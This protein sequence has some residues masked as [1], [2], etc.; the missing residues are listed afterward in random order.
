MELRD[1][2]EW[3]ADLGPFRG[4]DVDGGELQDELVRRG[5]LVEIPTPEGFVTDADADHVFVFTWSPHA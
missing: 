2:L 4:Q 5:L 3:I 1:A